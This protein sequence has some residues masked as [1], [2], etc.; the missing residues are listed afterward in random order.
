MIIL[1]MTTQ[2]QRHWQCYEPIS[3]HFHSFP[4]FFNTTKNASI[5]INTLVDV[6]AQKRLSFLECTTLHTARMLWSINRART[7]RADI[8]VPTL[9]RF[10]IGVPSMFALTL[11]GTSL[12]APETVESYKK[13]LVSITD[14][15]AW[16]RLDTLSHRHELKIFWYA[17]NCCAFN[18]KCT[19]KHSNFSLTLLPYYHF[20]IE[21]FLFSHTYI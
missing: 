6:R 2:R 5:S 12:S 7:L 19:L 11:P 17:C 8:S 4:P 10:G 1:M 15:V 13:Q 14:M 16:Y 18:C 3:Y 9:Q 20:L 21:F